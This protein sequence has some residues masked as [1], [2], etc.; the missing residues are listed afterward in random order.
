MFLTIPKSKGNV[1]DT[2]DAAKK[3]SPGKVDC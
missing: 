1:I 3:N 2:V